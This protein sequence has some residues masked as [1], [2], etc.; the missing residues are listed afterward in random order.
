MT[1][2]ET[3]SYT[4]LDVYKRQAVVLLIVRENYQFSL[5]DARKLVSSNTNT[6]AQAATNPT[7]SISSNAPKCNY[8]T[9]PQKQANFIPLSPLRQ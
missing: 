9:V 1:A 6:N 2:V 4:H 5:P 8:C 7:A 3:V